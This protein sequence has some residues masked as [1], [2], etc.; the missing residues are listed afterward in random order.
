M[1]D[2]LVKIATADNDK[3]QM[4]VTDAVS[5]KTQTT[6]STEVVVVNGRIAKET[7]GVVGKSNGGVFYNPVLVANKGNRKDLCSTGGGSFYKTDGTTKAEISNYDGIIDKRNLVLPT[8]ISNAKD[9]Q[10]MFYN[11]VAVGDNALKL[12]AAPIGSSVHVVGE[13]RDCWVGKFSIKVLW[14]FD[15]TLRKKGAYNDVC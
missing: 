11:L 14:V 12:A 15:M 9:E 2:I 4:V 8:I 3:K 10:P 13:L 1:E 7:P 6:V 5:G